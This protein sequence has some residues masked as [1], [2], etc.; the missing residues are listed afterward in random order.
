MLFGLG[1]NRFYVILGNIQKFFLTSSKIIIN[2]RH[3]CKR[4]SL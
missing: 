2:K 3:L 1:I 4:S